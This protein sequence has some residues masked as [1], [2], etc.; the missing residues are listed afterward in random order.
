MT[1][2]DGLRFTSEWILRGRAYRL[3]S[4]TIVPELQR[5][6]SSG[7]S[8][9]AIDKVLQDEYMP[10]WVFE[11]PAWAKSILVL[12]TP[13][14]LTRLRFRFR[15]QF[16]D[17]AVPPT[18]LGYQKTTREIEKELN[19]LLRPYGA[20]AETVKLPLKL[21]AAKSGLVRYGRNNI[22]YRPGSG[23][24]V[25]LDAC[26]TDLPPTCEPGKAEMLEE[27]GKCRACLRLCPTGV[28]N[29]EDFQIH[30]SRCL[31]FMNES[32]KDIPAWVSS[33]SHHCLIGCMKCQESCP[34]NRV[35][36]KNVVQ[37]G[38]FSEEETEAMLNGTS[39]DQLPPH[40]VEVISSLSMTADYALL[41]RNLRLVFGVVRPVL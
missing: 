16:R 8:R 7:C 35:V 14:A 37:G 29:E 25:Q 15:G 28:I 24:F 17:V 3:V 31:T 4:T 36:M 38:T 18:Y 30:A 27:C 20:R 33:G 6:I 11:A 13:K 10:T 21:L 23:S 5:E 2:Q 12:G 41:A 40:A 39:Y 1:Q 9:G 32:D 19:T 22:T 34:G 26:Y